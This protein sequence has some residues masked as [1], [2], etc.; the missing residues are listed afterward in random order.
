MRFRTIGEDLTALQNIMMPARTF[1]NEATA[2][3]TVVAAGEQYGFGNMIWRLK[4]AWVLALHESGMS[5]EAAALGALLGDSEAQRI[6][7]L[8]EKD[9]ALLI[10]QLKLDTRA[11]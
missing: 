6:V 2:V 4:M 3:S 8:A 10:Q 1:P 7:A 5:W 9:E 11:A